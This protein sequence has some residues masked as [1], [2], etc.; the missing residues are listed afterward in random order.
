MEQE[1]VNAATAE[2]WLEALDAV[3]ALEPFVDPALVDKLLPRRPEFGSFDIEI[4]WL[5][6]EKFFLDSNTSAKVV[7][8]QLF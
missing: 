1:L 3:K 8:A 5:R 4:R 2:R 7:L 6:A